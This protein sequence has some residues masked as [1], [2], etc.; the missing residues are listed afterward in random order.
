M[1]IKTPLHVWVFRTILM[2]MTFAW[3]YP[4]IFAF[5]TSFKTM[6]EFYADIWA[7]PQVFRVQNYVDAIV[8]G[9]I[10]DY[11]MNSL[12]IAAVSLLSIA[13]CSVLA[14]YALTRLRIPHPEAIIIFCFLIQLLPT[15]TVIIPLYI[16]MSRLGLLNLVYVPIILAYVGWS[17]PGTTVIL[18]NF[19]DTIPGELLEA[20]RIDGSGEVSTM[21][22]IVLPLMKGALSTCAVMN[23]TFIWGELMWARTA[24]LVRDR[25][26]PLTVGLINFKGEYGTDWPLLCAAICVIVIPLYLMFIFLQKHFVASLTAGGVKG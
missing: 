10:G 8:K 4:V 15:E 18:K 7:W 1:S 13:I 21:F 26:I 2:V 5:I 14:A 12:I 19:F 25:G 23:L 11:F 6:K 22:R 17:I 20:A 24:T 16:L 9:R 3:I